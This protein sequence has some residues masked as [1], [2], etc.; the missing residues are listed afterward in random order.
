MSKTITENKEI[1][2]NL[3]VGDHKFPMLALDP[4]RHNN[5]SWLVKEHAF[6]FY[7]VNVDGFAQ[8]VLVGRDNFL[9]VPALEVSEQEVKFIMDDDIE[10]GQE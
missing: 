8:Y 3:F 7:V 5:W 2:G 4:T 9:I 6:E 1:V 10:S